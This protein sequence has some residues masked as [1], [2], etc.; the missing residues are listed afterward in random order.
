MQL[1]FGE[2]C[3]L[4]AVRYGGKVNALRVCVG[5]LG[6]HSCNSKIVRMFLDLV[7]SLFNSPFWLLSGAMIDPKVQWGSVHSFCSNSAI[8]PVPL[9]WIVIGWMFSVF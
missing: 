3:Y 9:C 5:V 8:S 1:L 6:R 2:A 7:D 4:G